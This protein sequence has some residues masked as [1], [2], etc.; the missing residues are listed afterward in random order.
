[1]LKKIKYI[2]FDHDGTL[3]NTHSFERRFAFEGIPDL[4]ETLQQKKIP[5]YVWTARK[6]NSTK[7]I[8]QECGLLK[9]FKD[10]CGGDSA[11]AKPSADGLHYLLP[12]ASVENIIVIGDS[13]GD[14]VGAKSFGATGIGALWSHDNLRYQNVFIENGASQ[15]FA[16]VAELKNWILKNI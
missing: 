11:S 2:V 12:E 5:M 6:K 9:Y 3:V 14:I 15:T 7:E 8:L 10:I 1:M 13:I 4:L 16:D